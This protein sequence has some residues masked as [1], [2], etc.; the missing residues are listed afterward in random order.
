MARKPLIDPNL[1]RGLSDLF[2]G[3]G[4]TQETKTSLVTKKSSAKKVMENNETLEKTTFTGKPSKNEQITKTSPV[5]IK[6]S[7][8]EAD[9]KVE[10]RL[11]IPTFHA[12]KPMTEMSPV[13]RTSPETMSPATE[14]SPAPMTITSPVTSKPVTKMSLVTPKPMTEASPVSETSPEIKMSPVTKKSSAEGPFFEAAKSL[15][16]LANVGLLSVIVATLKGTSGMLPLGVVANAVGISK[17]HVLRQLEALESAGYMRT[18]TSG[19]TGRMIELTG[20]A[21][22]I[23]DFFVTGVANVT[24]PCSSCFKDINTTTTLSSTGDEYVT[25]RPKDALS[26]FTKGLR[27]RDVFLTLL[28]LGQDP[29]NMAPKTMSRL[30]ELCTTKS[31]QEIVAFL[32]EFV[33]QA[34]SNVSAYLERLLDAGALPPVGRQEEAKKLLEDIQ[35]LLRKVGV[36]ILPVEWVS[37]ARR[38]RVA[39]GVDNAVEKQEGLRARIDRY[40]GMV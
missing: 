11:E 38:F 39:A 5:T 28:H 13:T 15:N 7:P 25:R 34:K 14:M 36:E 32:L 4:V 12:P 9:T 21:K 3:L 19:Q 31:P 2:E 6:S 23:G 40:V 27:Y 20:D 30:V 37:L 22:V 29:E 33:P 1:E 17:R 8:E 16:S 10:D 24:G 35:A 18:L 26:F